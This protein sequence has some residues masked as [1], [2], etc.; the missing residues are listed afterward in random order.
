MV[1]LTFASGT[2][3]IR[4]VPA[5][6]ERLALP[7]GCA[8]DERTRCHRAPAVEYA[9]VVRALIAAKEPYE[10]GARRY[11]ELA[12]GARVHREPRP[13]QTEAFDAWKSA[14]GRGVVVLPS[15]A[16]KTDVAM[17]TID[18]KRRS[19]LVVA[20][21]LDL[22]RQWFDLLH[23]TFGVPDREPVGLVGGV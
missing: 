20:P 1:T 4:G 12:S 6:G 18:D 13:Y 11:S 16:G 15:G 8:W 2:I 7:A 17:M 22:V 23:H 5:S 9:S 21:T 19:A 3:E 10:D 14:R